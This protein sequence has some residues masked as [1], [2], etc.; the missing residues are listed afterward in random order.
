MAPS[1]AP[2]AILGRI[3][4]TAGLIFLVHSGYSAFE[5]LGYVKVLGKSEQTLPIEIQVECVISL[6]LC[7]V[8]VVMFSGPFKPISTEKEIAKRSMD[9]LSFKPSF[10]PLHHRGRYIFAAAAAAKS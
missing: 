5:H 2:L 1:N 4:F 9:Q 7:S 6:V 3:I 10:R 8:G